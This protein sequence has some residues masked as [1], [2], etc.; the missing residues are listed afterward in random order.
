M[1]LL[2]RSGPGVAQSTIPETLKHFA[3]VCPISPLLEEMI[4]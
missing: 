1:P 4:D 3:A 2:A